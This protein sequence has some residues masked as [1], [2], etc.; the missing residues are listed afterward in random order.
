MWDCR[1]ET[2]FQVSRK[3]CHQSKSDLKS[4]LSL[5]AWSR[6]LRVAARSI[7]LRTKGLPC[8][9]TFEAY[10]RWPIRDRRSLF[11]V[12]FLFN[13]RETMFLMSRN[14]CSGSLISILA[15]SSK[16]PKKINRVVGPSILSMARGKPNFLQML[17]RVLRFCL[18][19]SVRGFP[20]VRKSS[21]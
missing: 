18:H 21:S 8:G 2:P 3:R 12:T 17:I 9:T 1:H 16:I 5:I 15:E 14:F 4:W 7:I 10:V 11:E 19:S 20:A 6:S 13:Q